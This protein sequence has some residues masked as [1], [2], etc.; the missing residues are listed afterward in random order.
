MQLKTSVKPVELDLQ[1]KTAYSW[2]IKIKRWLDF[3]RAILVRT[4]STPLIR[5]TSL[6][7]LSLGIQPPTLLETSRFSHPRL[8]EPKIPPQSLKFYKNL[9]SK[10]Q[11]RITK[12]RL[13][14]IHC[15]LRVSLNSLR[16]HCVKSYRCCSNVGKNKF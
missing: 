4:N 9:A 12:V 15:H 10:N 16:S 11:I 7:S 2:G 3:R 6:T 8:L 14:P 13:T 5:K 1:I